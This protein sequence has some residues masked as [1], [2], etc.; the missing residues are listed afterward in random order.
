MTT[1]FTIF[2]S[3][4][5][6]V[7]RRL[8]ST[9]AF[10]A[11]ALASTAS[12]QEVIF[13]NGPPT[14]DRNGIEVT[15]RVLAEDVMLS[16]PASVERVR[17]WVTE[18]LNAWSGTIEYFFFA[19]AGTVPTETPLASGDGQNIQVVDDQ[20]T[21]ELETPVALDADVPYWIGI[22]MD[23][24][25]DEATSC[26]VFWKLLDQG[27]QNGSSAASA[28]GGDFSDWGLPPN[29]HAFQL[30]PEP[31]VVR[32]VLPGLGALVLLRG[33]RRRLPVS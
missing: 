5:S 25:F 33:R 7:V 3:R 11:L 22:H 30:L 23:A 29:H 18:D 28:E 17:L 20:Y 14:P 8:A 26:C 19:S 16:E 2:G 9:L 12:A 13:D 21:F 4:L 31:G 6:T 32:G 10:A 24:D 1:G 27:A 15:I